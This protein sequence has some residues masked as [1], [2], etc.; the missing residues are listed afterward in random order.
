[1]RPGKTDAVR[2]GLGGWVV[3]GE[4]RGKGRDQQQDEE[5]NG[6]RGGLLVAAHEPEGPTGHVSD[7]SKHTHDVF[8][9]LGSNN[10]VAMSAKKI[11]TSTA[12]VMSK[13]SACIV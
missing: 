13:N 3:R 2:V 6:A 8:L 12:T 11:A 10:A 7:E 9:V 5:D 1:M 4:P